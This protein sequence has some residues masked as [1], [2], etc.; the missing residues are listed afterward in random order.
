MITIISVGSN[1][2]FKDQ[3]KEY[4]VRI[5]HLSK[6]EVLELKNDKSKSET[7]VIKKEG[8]SLISRIKDKPFI[9]LDPK[10]VLLT[11]EDFA[12]MI[13]NTRDPIFVI[14]GANGLSA[15]VKA[16]AKSTISLSRMT[17]THEM[18]RILLLEQVYRAL[19]IERNMK[20]HK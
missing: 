19:T 18:A 15:D 6:A 8:E 16:R 5:N 10:G 9:A 7:E 20:Y 2:M 13:K 11:T 17:F 14:G 12:S 1:K 3:E 4:L